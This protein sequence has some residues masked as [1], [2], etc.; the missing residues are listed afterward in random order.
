MPRKFIPV[1]LA[2]IALLSNCGGGGGTTGTDSNPPPSLQN[3]VISG[4][5]IIDTS[6]AAV[7]GETNEAAGTI[8]ID[9][10]S[11]TFD[12]A[13]GN[14]LLSGGGS[15]TFLATEADV[16]A[17]FRAEPDSGS[18]RQG[19][20]GV[21]TPSDELPPSIAN[22]TYTGM[23][24]LIV[25]EDEFLWQLTGSSTVEADFSDGL[26]LVTI[27][28]LSG[29]VI[30]ASADSTD[31]SN[32]G[33]LTFSDVSIVNGSLS[34]GM[35]GLDSSQISSSLS[36]SEIVDLKGAFYGEQATAVGALFLVE[37]EAN[38]SIQGGLIGS[39]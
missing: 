10:L 6:I 9:D 29:V 4:Y 30:D 2:A 26:A 3:A 11:G 38:L 23:A 25:V 37:D 27:D 36:G 22:P 21:L 14:G 20:V 28:G 1:S 8:T 12:Y 24:S 35:A 16:V 34:G 19:I 17:Y 32:V 39:R 5:E 7:V 31:V 18:T 13:E 15:I 33:S